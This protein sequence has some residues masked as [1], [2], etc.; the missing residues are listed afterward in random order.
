MDDVGNYVGPLTYKAGHHMLLGK[1]NT[2]K[3]AAYPPAQCR[4]LADMVVY[5]I[6]RRAMRLTIPKGGRKK[7]AP[8]SSPSIT[9][10][11]SLL[12]AP[13]CPS[14]V[15]VHASR[16]PRGM[17]HRG[18]SSPEALLRGFRNLIIAVWTTISN[19]MGTIR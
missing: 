17:E 3:T 1:S 8:P 11:D 6:Q 18:T 14:G 7:D 19:N 2:W 4:K 13:S 5:S 16:C 12:A 15:G 10:F 9:P